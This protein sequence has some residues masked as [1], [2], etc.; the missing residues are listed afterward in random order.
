MDRVYWLYLQATG[1]QAI[2][3]RAATDY[4]ASILRT[5]GTPS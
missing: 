2:A 1:D 4:G 5:G 3:E